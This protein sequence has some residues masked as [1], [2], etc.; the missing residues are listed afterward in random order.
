MR[1]DIKAL[2]RS[3]NSKQISAIGESAVMSYFIALGY[4]VFREVADASP[5]DFILDYQDKLVKVQV[6]TL[7]PAAHDTY[8]VRLRKEERGRDF[9]YTSKMVDLL[10]VYLIDKDK[11]CF[12]RMGDFEGRASFSVRDTPTKNNQNLLVRRAD[13]H[14]DF[15]RCLERVEGIE[16]SASI[17]ARSR[18][19]TELHP[20]FRT[21]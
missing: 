5:V 6:K 21:D 9:Q 7:Q 13:D 10:A 3:R 8:Q 18:S 17:L 15:R 2:H 12:F 19:T 11:I 1:H 20:H 4:P 16:P 14:L